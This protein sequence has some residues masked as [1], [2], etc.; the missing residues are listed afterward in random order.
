MKYLA[1]R[2]FRPEAFADLSDAS[3]ASLTVLGWLPGWLVNLTL[4]I[5]VGMFKVV[6]DYLVVA[7]DVA[8]EVVDK[9]TALYKEGK[10]GSKD[11]MSIL[12][13]LKNELYVLNN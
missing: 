2:S 3:L 13:K 8:Q 4:R 6:R 1:Y 7:T 12:G 11:V 5:P 9:Q 10:E